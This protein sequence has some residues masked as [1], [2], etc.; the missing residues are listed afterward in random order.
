MKSIT[1]S[2]RTAAMGYNWPSNWL[3]VPLLKKVEGSKAFFPKGISKEINVIIL[4]TGFKHH[5]PFLADD[6]CLKTTDHLATT[7]L[8]KSVVWINNAKLFYIGLQ[9]KWFSFTMF[10]VQA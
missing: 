3:E 8:Y 2:Y 1:A 4:C 9:E 7:D 5:F 6:L 10:D